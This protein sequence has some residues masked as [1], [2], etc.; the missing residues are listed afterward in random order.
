VCWFCVMLTKCSF[1]P[2]LKN[3]LQVRIL[4]FNRVS[5]SP[6]SNISP[7]IGTPDTF[8]GKTSSQFWAHLEL[9]K[10]PLFLHI[11]L[12]IS[13]NCWVMLPPWQCTSVRR[14]LLGARTQHTKDAMW[15]ATAI[16]K[17][18]VI[19]YPFISIIIMSRILTHNCSSYRSGRKMTLFWNQLHRCLLMVTRLPEHTSSRIT[20]AATHVGAGWHIRDDRIMTIN[21]KDPLMG[22]TAKRKESPQIWR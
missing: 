2:N 11:T 17:G 5:V 14:K 20:H 8:K 7:C 9:D 12:N 19:R 16:V 4:K 21:L 10:T 18:F 3:R 13:S 15:T 22:K 6:L 1:L